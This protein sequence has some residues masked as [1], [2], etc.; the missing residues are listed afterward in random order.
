LFDIAHAAAMQGESRKHLLIFADSPDAYYYVTMIKSVFLMILSCFV[1]GI[2]PALRADQVVMQNG[3]LLNGTVLA[4]STNT[5][6]LQ[7]ANL[8]AVTLPR[9]KISSVTFGAGAA[10]ALSR[11]AS[12]TNILVIDRLNAE[13]TNS[14]SNSELAA[15]MREIRDQTNLIQQVQAQILGSSASPEAVNKFN[16]LLD[17][18]STGKIDMNE[19]RAE[20]QSAAD[21]LDSFTNEMEPDSSEEAAGYLSILNNFLEETAPGNI[22]TN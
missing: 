10:T 7:N 17:G 14:V 11:V 8:G 12:P 9:T 16:E 4:M 1:L 15:E 21:Q 13:E 5:L 22:S 20:A 18:L 6:M 3:D 2:I 19:L